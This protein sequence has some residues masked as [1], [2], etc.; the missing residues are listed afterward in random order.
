MSDHCPENREV[1]RH[2]LVKMAGLMRKG[3]I[4]LLLSLAVGAFAD[5]GLQ[6]IVEENNTGLTISSSRG[7]AN[8]LEIPG[9]IDGR[10]VTMIGDGAF[11]GKGLREVVIPDSVTVIGDGAFSY[12]RLTTVV[13]G[14]NVTSI[15]RGAFTSNRLISVTLGSSIVTIGKGAFS[16]NMIDSVVLPNTVSVIDDYAFFSNRLR[17][18]DFPASV[19]LIG[20][21]AFSGNRLTSIT[22][23]TGVTV[24]R[25]GAFYNNFITSVTIPPAL[26]NLGNRVFDARSSDGRI[27]GNIVYTDTS[28]NV[29]YTTANN[30]DAYYASSGRRPG[31][32]TLSEG[33]WRLE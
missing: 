14:N 28:G 32:Y 12:N 6:I 5:S 13:I 18:I 1:V 33:N 3:F 23:G 19:T 9:T 8:T 15:G 31:R 10:A 26:Q 27:R 30:F 29:L 7:S 21:G 16:N 20:E 2:D 22:V 24:I 25:D 17:S 4:L 11:I